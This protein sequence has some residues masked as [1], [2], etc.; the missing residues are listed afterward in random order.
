MNLFQSLYQLKQFLYIL[1]YLLF[2]MLNCV[3]KVSNILTA[4]LNHSV[5]V[6]TIFLFPKKDPPIDYV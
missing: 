1:K 4:K 2:H 6:Y 3:V 5:Y